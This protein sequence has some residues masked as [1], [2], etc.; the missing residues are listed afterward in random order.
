MDSGFSFDL[1]LL[2]YKDF[3]KASRFAK[4]NSFTGFPGYSCNEPAEGLGRGKE[5]RMNG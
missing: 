5:F 1:L 3:I 4:N 2:F